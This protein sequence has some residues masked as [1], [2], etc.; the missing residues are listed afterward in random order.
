[1][2]CPVCDMLTVKTHSEDNWRESQDAV[3]LLSLPSCGNSTVVMTCKGES[4]F[5]KDALEIFIG[6][7]I[8]YLG[9]ALKI[10]ETNWRIC[11]I[12]D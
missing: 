5:L 6:E 12:K 3:E 1:M 10:S 8:C 11:Y 9:F 7:I 2:P 4:L